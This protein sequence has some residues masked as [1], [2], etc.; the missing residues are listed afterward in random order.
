MSTIEGY[1]LDPQT[2]RTMTFIVLEATNDTLDCITEYEGEEPQA[3]TMLP[4]HPLYPY[5]SELVSAL[6]TPRSD[7]SDDSAT[8]VAN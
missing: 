6:H 7:A 8:H 1:V 3:I 2:R 5:L 4:D